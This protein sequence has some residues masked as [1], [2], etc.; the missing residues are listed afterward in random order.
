MTV[1]VNVY[2]GR[3]LI[4]AGTATGG[5]DTIASY[6]EVYP[7]YGGRNVQVTV[8]EEAANTI[9][10][11]FSTRVVTDETTSLVLKDACP[12]TD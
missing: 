3:I 12:F 4:G 6:T 8:T 7:A 2:K 10:M 9:G 1:A 11:T 5:S